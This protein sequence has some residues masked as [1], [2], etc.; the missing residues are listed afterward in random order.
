MQNSYDD[1]LVQDEVEKEL[2][3]RENVVWMS[4]PR[5]ASIGKQHL[6]EFLFA[7]PWTAF[8]LFWMAGASGL[9]FGSDVREQVNEMSTF[10]MIFPLFGLPF[11]AIGLWM[12]LKPVLAVKNAGRVLYVVTTERAFEM[13]LGSGKTITSYY[14]EDIGRIERSEKT[15]GSGDV[16]FTSESVSTNNGSRTRKV[17]FVGVENAR[18]LEE[19]LME[20]KKL[21]T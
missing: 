13:H 15:D 5:A 21:S 1:L 19:C 12:L 11:L 17:G 16:F 2:S 4:K 7:I 6:A 14:P 9:L 8:S 20:L 3:Y 18:E 10:N